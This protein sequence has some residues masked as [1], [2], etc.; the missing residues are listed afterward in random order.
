MVE[1][2]FAASLDDAVDVFVAAETGS[3][4]ASGCVVVVVVVA[5]SESDSACVIETDFV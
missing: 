3:G 1:A 2:D 4:Y 5:D